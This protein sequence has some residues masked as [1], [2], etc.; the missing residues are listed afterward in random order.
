MDPVLFHGQCLHSLA[1]RTCPWRLAVL[2]SSGAANCHT[3]AVSL[4]DC[5]GIDIL[6]VT[7]EEVKVKASRSISYLVT[8]ALQVSS[9]YYAVTAVSR[10][11]LAVGYR[12]DRGIDLIN[13]E[14]RVL[15]QICP[16]ISPD[17]MVTSDNGDLVCCCVDGKIARVQVDSGKIIFN[18]SG[19]L[20]SQSSVLTVLIKFNQNELKYDFIY[21]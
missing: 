8:R 20:S 4:P 19:L 13:L 11:S 16:N 3:V 1:C 18:N 6:E 5:Q 2:D 21:N 10:Q 12:F 15:R 14:G 9:E 7:A 17:Y